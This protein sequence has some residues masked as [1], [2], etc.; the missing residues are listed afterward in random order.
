M[1]RPIQADGRVHGVVVA[2]RR[3]DGCWLLIRRSRHVRAPRMVCFPGGAVEHDEAQAI[4]VVR[5]MK[6]ELGV[7]VTPL[8][9]CWRWDSPTTNLTLFGW[10]A[11][12]ESGELRPDPFEVEE[13]LWL[14]AEE[15]TNHP[16][17]METNRDFIACLMREAGEGG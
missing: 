9:Q 12:L 5:E 16:D 13:I 10:T 14:S 2:V 3:E 17:A 4:A 15:G 7:T 6:E 8:R 1:S 11:L